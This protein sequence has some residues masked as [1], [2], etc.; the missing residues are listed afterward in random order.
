[1]EVNILSILPIETLALILTEC[2]YYGKLVWIDDQYRESQ[3][4]SIQAFAS[5]CKFSE[6]YKILFMRLC[7]LKTY[8]RHYLAGLMLSAFENNQQTFADSI[9]IQVLHYW[10]A[11]KLERF[12]MTKGILK[13]QFELIASNLIITAIHC[14]DN[15]KWNLKISD[16]NSSDYKM[17]PSRIFSIF[18]NARLNNLEHHTKI[19]FRNTQIIIHSRRCNGLSMY[20]S[21]EKTTTVLDLNPLNNLPISRINKYWDIPIICRIQK[22]FELQISKSNIKFDPPFFW[23]T[24]KKLSYLDCH[25]EK[26]YWE[27]SWMIP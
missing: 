15:R 11:T 27:L 19:I 6:P 5:V 2:F 3:I 21:F 7:S 17:S 22:L 25:L 1:M 4:Q 10:N 16:Q 18:N 9:V 12:T 8:N 24:K 23:L 26:F 20:S 14:E 13:Y